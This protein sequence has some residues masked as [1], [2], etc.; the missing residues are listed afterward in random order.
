MARG[1]H[2][3][4]ILVLPRLDIVAVMTGIMRDDEYYPTLRLVDDIAWSVKSDKSLPPDSIAQSLLAASIRE[5]ATEKRS[6]VGGTP[7]L[8]KAISGKVYLF[9]D[10]ALHVKTFSLDLAGSSPSWE[11]TTDTGKVER[12]SGLVGLE[13][14]FRMSPP[15]S[16]GINATKG[17]WLNE[18]AFAVE[19]RI[20]GAWR[21]PGLD[22]RLRR[23]ENRCP[24]RIDG[25]TQS[26]IARRG[27]GLICS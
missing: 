18:H 26:R 7:A 23:Q 10:N 4:L 16:Y 6:P 8:A 12:F 3:Q 13:G 1:R 5:A 15:A 9:S 27:A 14:V 11:I 22:A 20:L 21:N 19:R 17:R 25:R 24:F 2:S